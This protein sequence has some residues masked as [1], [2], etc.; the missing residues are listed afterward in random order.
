MDF[1]Q[2]VEDLSYSLKESE[3]KEERLFIENNRILEESDEE[4]TKENG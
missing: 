1:K 4:E 2:F 3:L